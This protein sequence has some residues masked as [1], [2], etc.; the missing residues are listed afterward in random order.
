MVR[1][2]TNMVFGAWGTNKY[3]FGG[4]TGDSVGWNGIWGFSIICWNQCSQKPSAAGIQSLGRNKHPM[5]CHALSWFVPW[6]KQPRPNWLSW[7]AEC[8]Y[9]LQYWHMSGTAAQANAATPPSWQCLLLRTITRPIYY[10]LGYFFRI[11]SMSAFSQAIATV[12]RSPN[13]LKYGQI[14]SN[15]LKYAQNMPK[16]QFGAFDIWPSR[17]AI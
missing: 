16:I 17:T 10:L 11:N 3:G 13:T 7:A 8:S 15:M 2:Q 4:L 9:M 6:H 1:K 12:N 5:P 14:C